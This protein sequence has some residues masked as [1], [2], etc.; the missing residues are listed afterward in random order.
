[1]LSRIL[2]SYAHVCP[3]LLS[4]KRSFNN[5]ELLSKP[6]KITPPL[7]PPILKK[8][9]D[10]LGRRKPTPTT[11]MIV[12]PVK[13]PQGWT[14]SPKFASSKNSQVFPEKRAKTKNFITSWFRIKCSSG[15]SGGF[16]CS[17]GGPWVRR[18]GG[19]DRSWRRSPERLRHQTFGTP[20]PPP[21]SS[22][23]LLLAARLPVRY[24]TALQHCERTLVSGRGRNERG[25]DRGL[26]NPPSQ[27]VNLNPQGQW[28]FLGNVS[29]VLVERPSAGCRPVGGRRR[30]GMGRGCP[31]R[32]QLAA[33]EKKRRCSSKAHRAVFCHSLKRWEKK[34][35]D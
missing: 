24:H 8:A 34:I 20:P 29:R 11:C 30:R 12:A 31:K 6:A 7:P 10:F 28:L 13:L 19:G 27:L 35:I 3:H 17:Q 21:P 18:R 16:R 23:L 2:P 9:R 22:L 33:T 32:D 15:S 14:P 4:T 1:M 25:Q 5:F 26:T